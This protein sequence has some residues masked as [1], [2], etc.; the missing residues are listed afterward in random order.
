MIQQKVTKQA[1]NP[2]QFQ[3]YSRSSEGG[4]DYLLNPQQ[5]KGPGALGHRIIDLIHCHHGVWIVP[6]R[7]GESQGVPGAAF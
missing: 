7:S 6:R 5:R 1:E 4:T 3:A 2:S